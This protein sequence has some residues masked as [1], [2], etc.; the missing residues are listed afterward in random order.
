MSSLGFQTV[1]HGFAA[2]PDVLAERVFLEG[3]GTRLDARDAGFE[4]AGA[5][6]LAFS[7]SGENDY[8]NLLRALALAGLPLRAADR[9][10][11]SPLV[12]AG[13]IAPTLNPEPIAPFVDAV[14]VG[15]GEELLAPLVDAV[16]G[17]AGREEALARLAG[18]P[19]IYLPSR[20]TP[21]YA[22]DGTLAAF[23]PAPGAPERVRRASVADLDAWET[24]GRTVAPGSEFEDLCLVEA[25][26][27]C[28]RG[29][30]FC[31]AGHVVRPLR[32]RSLAA[33]RRAVAAS[34]DLQPRVGLLGAAVGDHPDLVA[35]GRELIAAGRGFSLSSLR[36]DRLDP[37]LLELLAAAGTRTATFAPETG[38]ERLRRVVGKRITDAQILDAAGRA[39]AAGLRQ[40][41]LYFMLGLPTET[42][43]DRDAI[44]DLVARVRERT[45]AGRREK[46]DLVRIAVTLGG[47]VPKAWTPFQ[48]HPFA[49]VRALKT[50]QSAVVRQLQ[51]IPNVGVTHDVPKWSYLQALL[52]LG[53]RR[54][55]DVLE[56]AVAGNDWPA[57][58][59]GAAVDPDFFVLREKGRDELLP[60]DFIDTGLTKSGL[61]AQ[62]ERALA[63]DQG[64]DA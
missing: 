39:A 37:D 20:Y 46:T 35:L 56:A 34:A 63:A 59:R 40:I 8:E 42:A 38:S 47:F 15:E 6:L 3:D 30:R 11:G 33:L 41:K 25:S 21:R 32:H 58:L 1:L 23:D 4:P 18:A 24:F 13:G 55:A 62:Y 48:W 51:K 5:D 36:L 57:A 26:R 29:C 28:G 31:A 50:A 64:E 16:R 17:R 22:A 14:A 7:I 49:G 45:L 27:G 53:D 12:V 9:P 2:L 60:W 61:R 54:V 10:Q 44:A 43:A 19:G 52:S